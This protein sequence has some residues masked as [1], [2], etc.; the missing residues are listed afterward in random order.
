MSIDTPLRQISPGN[1]NE[2]PMDLS[3]I[4]SLT[5]TKAPQVQVHLQLQYTYIITL[6]ET[7]LSGTIYVYMCADNNV[8]G[9]WLGR[10]TKAMWRWRM[11]S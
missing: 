10:D 5:V 4:P 9:L 7:N 8:C 1:G 6:F 11:H 3:G 2:A